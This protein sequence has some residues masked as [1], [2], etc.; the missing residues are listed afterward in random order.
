MTSTAHR[1][2]FAGDE[3]IDAGLCWADPD[4]EVAPETGSG[5]AVVLGFVALCVLASLVL[6]VLGMERV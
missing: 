4:A 6:L 3:F 2:T 1:E 5:G